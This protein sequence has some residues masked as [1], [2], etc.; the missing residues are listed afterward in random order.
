MMC[1]K[2]QLAESSVAMVESCSCG[3]WHLHVGPVTL[4]FARDAF[5][6]LVHTVST[7]ASVCA[8]ERLQAENDLK[9]LFGQLD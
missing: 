8:T 1:R 5:A 3:K 7:A 6:E 4:H 2:K 9:L